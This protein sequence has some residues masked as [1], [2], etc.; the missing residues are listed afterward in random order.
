MSVFKNL[1][2]NG[3]W[4]YD[5][6]L[7][8]VRHRGYCLDDQG[9]PVTSRTAAK[10]SEEAVRVAARSGQLADRT[11]GRAGDYALAQ[12]QAA[13]V[14]RAID[15]KRKP[16][17]VDNLVL[18]GDHALEHFGAGTPFRTLSQKDLDGYAA[19][20]LGE[21]VRKWLGGNRRPTAAERKDPAMWRDTGRPLS[22][23]QV[24]N[25]LK[26]LRRLLEIAAKVRDPVT[27]QPV[28]GQ[29]PELT[30]ELERVPRRKP[31]PMTD[32][33]LAQR[34]AELTP[35]ARDAAE[36][37]RL[38]GLRAGEALKACRRHVDREARALFFR[39]EETKSGHD[40]HAY[41]GA[42]G[43]KLL[44]RLDRQAE[45]RG[46]QHLVTW[47]G[48]IHVR[49]VLA[50][51]RPDGLEWRPLKTLSGSW[52]KS[53]G[54]AGVA[55]PHRFHDV[56]ARYITAVA[57]ADKAATKQAAR[58]QDPAT[59]DLYISVADDEVRQAV[60]KAVAR[61]PKMKARPKVR[62]AR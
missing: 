5:F 14:Q 36:L 19:K 55:D 53:A 56:R 12:A 25:Y 4:S 43:W 41:G 48:P 49:A 27:R 31:R 10:A 32:R 57:Q 2:R 11:H 7:G 51:R 13:I 30:I 22:K 28:L 1:Q 58:H 46:V 23:R 16:G 44:Q 45:R 52:R 9:Q 40:E 35:W 24:N 42:A 26:H 59:T 20:L 29:D 21:T 60:A 62:A 18:W 54:R 37:S 34:L 3:A 38:F 6:W 8:G 50:G 33:E 17:H 61:R 39:G 47:P 15:R